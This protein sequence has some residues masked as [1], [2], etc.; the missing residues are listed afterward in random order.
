MEQAQPKRTKK[1]I[2]VKDAERVRGVPGSNSGQRDDRVTTRRQG[3]VQQRRAPLNK[4]CE[5]RGSLQEEVAAAIRAEREN[6]APVACSGDVSGILI[7]PEAAWG[8]ALRS[9]VVQPAEPKA[10]EP[11]PKHIARRRVWEVAGR[12]AGEAGPDIRPECISGVAYKRREVITDVLRGLEESGA[13]GGARGGGSAAPLVS[14]GGSGSG[15]RQ[16]GVVEAT[17]VGQDVDSAPAEGSLQGKSC[18]R[19]VAGWGASSR[20]RATAQL[21]GRDAGAGAPNWGGHGG[22]AGRR[23]RRR[24]R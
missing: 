2:G 19:G 17:A 20:T 5:P 22:G 9:N 23:A 13:R 15:G 14:L 10:A 4:V 8:K 16:Q 18:C 7:P 21:E 1:I 11:L 24:G 12:A 6:R 3:Q